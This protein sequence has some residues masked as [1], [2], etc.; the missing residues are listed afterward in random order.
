MIKK[1]QLLSFDGS[2]LQLPKFKTPIKIKLHR[3][4]DEIIK[5]VTIS[6][7][8]SGKYYASILVDDALIEVILIQ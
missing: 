1:V 2:Y 7:T 6:Q 3:S 5:S 4:F 8:P